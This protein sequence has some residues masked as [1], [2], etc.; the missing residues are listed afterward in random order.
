M[1]FS[2]QEYWSGLPCPPLGDLPN[3]GIEPGSL[4][5]WADSLPSEPS[6]K[7]LHAGEASF[8]RTLAL[9]TTRDPLLRLLYYHCQIPQMSPPLGV[10]MHKQ[11]KTSQFPSLCLLSSPAGS[12]LPD[13]FNFP[14]LY[15]ISF[16]TPRPT[17][18][19]LISP[20]APLQP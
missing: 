4:T 12:H 10:E 2:R 13:T 5:L 9:S 11:I 14:L 1:G 3:P 16:P 19:F 18:T 20:S 17:Q 15:G 7:P 8:G 6:E